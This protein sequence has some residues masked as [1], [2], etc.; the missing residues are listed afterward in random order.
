VKIILSIIFLSIVLNAQDKL[1]NVG[2][3]SKRGDEVTLARW[4]STIDYLSDTIE[5]YQFKIVPLGFEALKKSVEN[6]EIDFVLTNTMYYVQLEY[7]YGISRIATLKNS[8]NNG[9]GLTSFGGVIFT[10]KDSSIKDPNDLKGKRFGAVNINSFGGWV[11]AQKELKDKGITK[12]DFV[13]FEFFGSHDKVVQAVKNKTVD[14]G[15]VRSDTLERMQNDG[16]INIDEFKVILQKNYKDFP[17][18]VSTQLYPEWPFAKLSSTSEKLSNEVLMSLL[19]IKHDSKIAQESNVSGWTIPMDYS[20]VHELLEELHIGPYKEMGKLTFERFYEEHRW[21]FYTVIVIFALISAVA[22]HISKLNLRL[23]ESKN[24]I[25]ELNQS[26]ELKVKRRTAELEK[27]YLE[28]KLLKNILQTIS[29]IN[30]LLVSSFSKESIIENSLKRLVQQDEYSFVWIGLIEDDSL[31]S[32]KQYKDC[33]N[34]FE[35]HRYCLDDEHS[36]PVLNLAKRSIK[37]NSSIIE[38]SQE[39][40]E[41]LAWLASIPIR[42]GAEG[43]IIGNLSVYSARGDGFLDREIKMLEEL[44]TD[45]GTALNSI[46]QKTKLQEMEL[47]KISNYEETILAFVNIIEQ[48]DNYTAGHTIR[49]AEYC[50]L[51]AEAMNIDDLEVKKLEKAAILHDIGKV[52]TPDSIL[53]KPGELTSLEYNLIKEHSNAGYQMLSKIKM[54]QDLADIIK[55]HHSNYNGEGYPFV[56]KDKLDSIPMLSHIMMVADAFDAMTSNRIYKSR[57]T[58]SEAIQELKLFSGTQFHPDIVKVA[59]E[60]L[61][62]VELKDSSQMPTSELE[63]RRFAYFFMDSLTDLYNEDYLKIELSK[64]ENVKK[65]LV[66]IEISD[67]SSYNKKHGWQSGNDLLKSFAKYLK[68]RFDTATVFR[69]RGDDFVLIFENEEDLNKEDFNEFNILEKE[70][71]GF[72]VK[73]FDLLSMPNLFS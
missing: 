68:D 12:D 29:D 35:K 31:E 73:R 72:K 34:L 17:F 3:L 30:E 57:K 41:S 39:D 27:M 11:M 43:E 5:G 67:F 59:I 61:K 62:D 33:T 2:V 1:V 10:T 51:I 60:V 58:I 56:E 7:L 4:S 18:L 23:K 70:G 45:I 44:A 9:K 32:I 46:Y 52:V 28:E 26:L 55:Y 19:K 6:S 8:S 54:Y 50:R 64:K 40:E 25:E 66:M 42:A 69:Y 65:H 53:L 14:A 48:R 37:T 13:S 15:T 71:V 24:E 63:Q 47:E 22:L 16:L 36:D 38:E 21:F 20:K 49:V